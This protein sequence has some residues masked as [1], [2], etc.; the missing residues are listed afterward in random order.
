MGLYRIV[1]FAIVLG[2]GVVV[3]VAWT[4]VISYA[5]FLLVAGLLPS[6]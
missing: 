6:F 4:G 5:L 2:L 3:S 1:I